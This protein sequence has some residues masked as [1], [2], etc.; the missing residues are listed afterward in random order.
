MILTIRPNAFF[1]KVQYGIAFHY[2]DFVD[3]QLRDVYYL[4]NHAY[5]L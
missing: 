2:Y 3:S 4:E 1:D 5:I